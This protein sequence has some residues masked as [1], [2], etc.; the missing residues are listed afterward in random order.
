MTDEQP[1]RAADLDWAFVVPSAPPDAQSEPTSATPAPS[2]W[3]TPRRIVALVAVAAITTS[4]ATAVVTRALQARAARLS[5]VNELTRGPVVGGTGTSYAFTWVNSDGSPVRWNPCEPIRWVSSSAGAPAGA[6]S[7]FRDAVA[8]VTA[9]TGLRFEYV[10]EVEER[11]VVNRPSASARGGAEWA[12]V[13]VAWVP[14]AGTPLGQGLGTGPDTVGVAT[15]V[16]ISRPNSPGVIVSGQIVFE[17]G[18]VL[19]S[20]FATSAARGSV[21]LH[22]LAHAV[23]LAH[24]TDPTQLMYSGDHAGVT[25]GDFGGGDRLGLEG[26]GATGGCVDTPSP[27][28]VD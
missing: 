16:A 9:L 11:P 27:D 13:L 10:G 15:P 25:V 2:A 6:L 28:E 5:A 23:G 18:R 1:I 20:G 26:L 24:V 4:A 12:P 17:T 14:L 3:A 22:E 8:H 7:D 21:M 19:S